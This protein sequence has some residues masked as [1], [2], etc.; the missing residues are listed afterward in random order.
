VLQ[1]RHNLITA[2][3]HRIGDLVTFIEAEV[4][5]VVE[6]VPGSLGLSMYADAER[7]VAVLESFWASREALAESEQMLSPARHE[8]V[9]RVTGTVCVERYRVPVFER[10]GP[11]SAG[12]GLRLTRMDIEPSEVEDAIETYGDT[13]VPQVAETEGFCAALLLTQQS[14]GHSISETIWQTPEALAATRSFAAELRVDLAASTGGVI[15]A[16]EEYGLIFSSA[17]QA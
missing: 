6:S 17:R 11:L 8:A 2:D 1:A 7:G 5:P 12:T 13:V 15:R 3:P 9:R 16:V 10:E 4:R 14:T